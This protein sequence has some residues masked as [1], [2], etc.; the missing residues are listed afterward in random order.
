MLTSPSAFLAAAKATAV[1]S[2]EGALCASF[3]ACRLAFLSDSSLA[4]FP[5]LSLLATLEQLPA[6]R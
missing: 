1:D 6:T 4:L 5:G 2:A 3:S